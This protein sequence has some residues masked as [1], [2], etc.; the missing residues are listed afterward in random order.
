MNYTILNNYSFTPQEPTRNIFPM[1]S[2]Y[3]TFSYLYVFYLITYSYV[4]SSI[5]LMSRFFSVLSVY[6]L[7]GCA[8]GVMAYCQVP[9]VP[10]HVISNYGQLDGLCLLGSLPIIFV[11]I[12]F[13]IFIYSLANKFSFSLQHAPWLTCCYL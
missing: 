3:L 7:S 1:Y 2:I 9:N 5:R 12:L 13:Y 11:F 6:F 8:F 4:H 10:C